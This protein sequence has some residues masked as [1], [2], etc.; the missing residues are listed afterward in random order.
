MYPIRIWPFHEAPKDL[1][2][3]F[4]GGD[5]DYVCVYHPESQYPHQIECLGCCNNDVY[6]VDE[7]GVICRRFYKP[8][9][10]DYDYE[11][12]ELKAPDFAGFMVVISCHA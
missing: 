3:P 1:Q 2:I 7:N 5:E 4:N 8:I 6:K 10:D 12:T 11:P 9:T